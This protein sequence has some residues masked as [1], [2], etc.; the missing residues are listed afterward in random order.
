MVG[1]IGSEAPEGWIRRLKIQ[2]A[3]AVLRQDQEGWGLDLEPTILVPEDTFRGGNGPLGRDGASRCPRHQ[4]VVGFES[5]AGGLVDALIVRCAPLRLVPGQDDLWQVTPEAGRLVGEALGNDAGG[6]PQP[7][8]NCPAGAFA[9]GAA[10]RAGDDIDR[11]GLL[12][13]Q[14]T[15]EGD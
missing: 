12:C 8:V 7:V 13:A 5:N 3:Q 15:F 9:V 6:D 10:V 4:A 2:C 11:F 14:A 1:L